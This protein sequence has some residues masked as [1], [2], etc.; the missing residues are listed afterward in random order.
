[1]KRY[2]RICSLLCLI[3]AA[4]VIWQ[5]AV[6]PMGRVNKPGPGFL[7]FWVA[8]ILALLSAFLWMEAGLRK[9]PSVPVQFLSGEG[10]W[11]SVLLTAVSLLAYAFLI[12]TLGFII[13]TLILLF[14]LFRFV[15]NQKWWVVFTETVL[16]TLVTHLIF[17]VGLKVQLPAGLFRI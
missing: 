16:V 14:F 3:I 13:S 4:I 7:P 2:D 17:K 5:S 12:E 11:P 15:G 8:V 6:I 1:M 10:R 9:A